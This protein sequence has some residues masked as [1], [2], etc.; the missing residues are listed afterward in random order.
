MTSFGK[1]GFLSGLM[2][3]GAGASAPDAGPPGDSERAALLQHHRSS[4][5]ASVHEDADALPAIDPTISAFS[6]TAMEPAPG[7]LRRRFMSHDGAGG[8]AAAGSSG[9]FSDS[10]TFALHRRL[11]SS[12]QSASNGHGLAGTAVSR[13][14]L[15]AQRVMQANRLLHPIE[16]A[17]ERHEPG[18][19]PGIDPRR[20]QYQH[21]AAKWCLPVSVTMVDYDCRDV[22]IKSEEGAG[23]LADFL[24][25]PR[26]RG[27][28]VRWIHVDGLNWEVI[29]MLAL[30]YD[31]HPLALEDTVHVPQRIKADFYDSCLYVSLIYLYLAAGSMDPIDPAPVARTARM[32]ETPRASR[33]GSDSDFSRPYMPRTISSARRAD[34]EAAAAAIAA[35]A[36]L[37]AAASGLSDIERAGSSGTKIAVQRT[38]SNYPGPSHYPL[39]LQRGS[40]TL[41]SNQGLPTAAAA[42]EAV[43]AAAAA[44][45]PGLGTATPAAAWQSIAA[46]RTGAH[47]GRA[48]HV[49][50]QQVSLFLLRGEHQNTLITI[51]QSDGAAVTGPILAQLKEP[52]TLV[53]EAEDASFLANLV[54]DTLVDHIFP[55][56][57]AY[58]E[59]LQQYEAEIMGGKIP[60]AASTRELHAMQ[61]DLRRIDRTIAPLQAVV[62]NIVNRDSTRLGEVREAGGGGAGGGGVGGLAGAGDSFVSAAAIPLS[63]IAVPLSPAPS[64]S[65]SGGAAAPFLSRLTRTYLGDVRDHVST[66]CEDLMSLS[67]ECGDLI[68]LIFNLTTHQQ[69]QSTQTLAVVS[70]IFLPITFLAG[71][72]GMNFDDLP[73][74]HWAYGYGYFW[75]TSFLI[76]VVFVLAMWRAGMLS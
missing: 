64:A 37:E 66:I 40:V 28:R 26:P 2:G 49:S 72:Y 58:T 54:I 75:T 55:V 73:E 39:P 12:G 52:R 50:A 53:R 14:Q 45:T 13:W 1:G 74:L 38:A 63:P 8:G 56:V 21:L 7:A 24:R 34:A 42:A 5:L 43:A 59:Q 19:A 48:I 9:E 41:G 31:L 3:P 76:V 30:A 20:S 29:Q 16:E 51:F 33:D 68:G 4:S 36:R 18:A 61:R 10:P 47:R 17:I 23:G 65:V 70:T 60:S 67:A 71:V 69:S 44:A 57:G 25:Q 22:Y 15:S 11:S 27:S 32:P 6:A 62:S 46:A 35:A